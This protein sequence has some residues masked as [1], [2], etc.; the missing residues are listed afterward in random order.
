MFYV[1]KKYIR[2][3]CVIYITKERDVTYDGVSR[4]G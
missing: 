1:G 2:I 3:R 4:T